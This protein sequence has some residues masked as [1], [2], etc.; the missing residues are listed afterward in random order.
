MM[1]EMPEE[2]RTKRMR[3]NFPFTEAEV[4]DQFREKI[5]DFS[6]EDLRRLERKGYAESEI[7]DGE[8]HY[9]RCAVRTA[10]QE[11]K[12]LRA[13]AGAPDSDAE[14]KKALDQE[15]RRMK[16]KG[17]CSQRFRLRA[18]IRLADKMFHPG[19]TIRAHLP[20]PAELHQT[21]DVKILAHAEGK[22]SIDAPQS[23]YRTICFEDTLEENREFFV[24]YAYTVTLPYH[25]L[26]FGMDETGAHKKPDRA[27]NLPE[28]A[29]PPRMEN[30][31]AQLP[32]PKECL[33][34][35]APHILF[36]PALR[37]LAGKITAGIADDPAGPGGAALRRAEAIYRYVTTHVR[38]AYMRDYALFD[39]I[40]E[41]CART[42]RGDCGV[43]ALLFITL[44]RIC[45]IPATWQSG[46]YF[47]GRGE[48]GPHDWALFFVRPYGWLWA[49][50]SLGGSAFRAGR[51]EQWKFYFGN[52]DPFRMIANHAFMQPFAVP[53]KFPAGDPCDNQVGEI[54]SEERGYYGREVITE[55]R[56]LDPQNI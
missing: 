53:K 16:E 2:L 37:E 34:E 36:T 3:E 49:D 54:E 24:E 19:M 30:G 5:P 12:D 4:L 17:G 55:E 11:E 51:E 41:Y 40:P 43:Q 9:I 32:E 48:P 21:S 15:I 22:V 45:G 20:I 18:S 44:C 47:G 39:N 33:Q 7:L 8:K 26:P 29:D 42:L 14:E 28:P 52:V 1:T 13:R 10:L 23:L 27:G 31:S 35:Q 56:L 46:L 6:T 50:P 25:D 38:Y